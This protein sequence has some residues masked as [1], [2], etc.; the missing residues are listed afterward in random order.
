MTT[1]HGFT[2][3]DFE[4]STEP[5]QLVPVGD[6]VEARVTDQALAIMFA[7]F[8]AAGSPGR[9]GLYPLSPGSSAE[10]GG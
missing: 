6:S 1:P 8:S 2:A 4:A 7:S 3:T 10:P 9:A 5:G